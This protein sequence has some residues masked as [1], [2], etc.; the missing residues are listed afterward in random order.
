MG[1]IVKP[2]AQLE[3]SSMHYNAPSALFNA[4]NAPT[5]ALAQ[6]VNKA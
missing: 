3:H 6:N 1:S 5:S 4:L 2:H